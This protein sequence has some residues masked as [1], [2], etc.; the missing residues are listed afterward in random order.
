MVFFS[1]CWFIHPSS[2]HLPPVKKSLT[3]FHRLT[4]NNAMIVAE[5]PLWRG[6]V[7]R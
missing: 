4:V 6:D 1:V 2:S 7:G 5:K 3:P